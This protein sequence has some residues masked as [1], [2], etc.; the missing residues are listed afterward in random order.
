[1]AKEWL[2]PATT[3]RKRTPAVEP[4]KM[5]VL[6]SRFRPCLRG[7]CPSCGCSEPS[8]L[9]QERSCAFP[10][11]KRECA[12]P[13]ARGSACCARR[14]S[15]QRRKP[16]HEDAQGGRGGGGEACGALEASEKRIALWKRTSAQGE[17][18]EEEEEGAG[19]EGGRPK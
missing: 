5:G 12:S 15:L 10:S 13:A 7:P 17:V 14:E 2:F 9:P 19:C 6:I 11:T 16:T 1:M 3:A 4:I 8:S 18:G